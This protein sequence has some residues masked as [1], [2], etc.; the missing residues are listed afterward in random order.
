MGG[1]VSGS[2]M[3]VAI[4]FLAPML[5]PAFRPGM[6]EVIT[7]A[8]GVA[9][10]TVLLTVIITALGG[11]LGGIALPPDDEEGSGTRVSIFRCTVA[12]TMLGLLAGVGFALVPG[13]FE[14][15]QVV[16]W[17]TAFLIAGIMTSLIGMFLGRR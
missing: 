6:P 14:I 5:P 3:G 15:M 13:P 4:L 17:S 7:G 1:V 9:L 16:S 10:A 11:L 2:L 12:T 8:L